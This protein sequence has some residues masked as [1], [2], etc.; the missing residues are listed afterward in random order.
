MPCCSLVSFRRWRLW[1]DERRFFTSEFSSFAFP[2]GWCILRI[3]FTL[4]FISWGN[5]SI[6]DKNDV[7]ILV[8]IAFS[9]LLNEGVLARE[10]KGPLILRPRRLKDAKRAMG[11]EIGCSRMW[12]TRE[13]GSWVY[14]RKTNLVWQFPGKLLSNTCSSSTSHMIQSLAIKLS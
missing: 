3:F 1:L 14:K 4:S 6:Y 8:P 2:I 5:L 11:M 9:R 10:M 13:V 12:T 7:L